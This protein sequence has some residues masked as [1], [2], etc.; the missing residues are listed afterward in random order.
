MRKKK[1]SRRKKRK[2]LPMEEK[3]AEDRVS[4]FRKVEEEAKIAVVVQFRW[5]RRRRL[6][7]LEK[8]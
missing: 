8:C 2:T 7:K 6:V 4:G 5:R 1:K 3:E